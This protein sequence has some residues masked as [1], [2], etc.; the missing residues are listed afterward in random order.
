MFSPNPKN[1]PLLAAIKGVIAVNDKHRDAVDR[2]NH[3]F[4]ITDKR[5]LPHNLHAQYDKMLSESTVIVEK[6]TKST[7]MGDVIRDFEK[8]DAPQ[9][10]G[11]SMEKR[12]Q[13][14]IAAKMAMNEAL[15]GNQHKIDANKNGKVDAQDFKMLRKDMTAEEVM[16]EAIA[17]LAEK[18]SLSEAEQNILME[19]DVTDTEVMNSDLYKNA[20]KSLG[21]KDPRKIQIGQDIEGLGKFEKGDNIFNKV[22]STLSAQKAAPAPVAKVEPATTRS[23]V[24]VADKFNV[25]QSVPG[26]TVAPAPSGGFDQTD[27]KP[28]EPNVLN[29]PT[30]VTPATAT[31]ADASAA[32]QAYADQITGRKLENPG[33]KP[34][35]GARVTPAQAPA[36][37]GPTK[38]YPTADQVKPDNTYGQVV[39]NGSTMVAGQTVRNDNTS[40]LPTQVTQPS[41]VRG[42]GNDSLSTTIK[43]MYADRIRR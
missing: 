31:A 18:D 10:E 22:K 5:Q 9:F 8:S 16:K 2:A 38:N 28:W 13:M 3:H 27:R 30:E 15:K 26:A 29:T 17:N 36:S 40:Q 7:P 41:T 43:S 14:A 32:D 37:L 25:K 11:K 4:Q 33:T 42:Y 6:I 24:P 23:V 34:Y 21:G 1:D 20:L 19:L 12:R 35:W 39:P